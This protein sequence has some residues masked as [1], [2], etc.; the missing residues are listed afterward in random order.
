M[1]K[2]HYY[3]V[4]GYSASAGGLGLG[5]IFMT[6]DKDPETKE[7]IETLRMLVWDAAVKDSPGKI[8]STSVTLIDW[9][10]IQ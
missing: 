3:I 9:K 1:E 6:L 8:V 7:E 4:F 5:S 10:R 2:F